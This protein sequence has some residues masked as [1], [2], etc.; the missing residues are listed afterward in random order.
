MLSQT[1][2]ICLCPH[3]EVTPKEVRERTL[4]TGFA[5]N[6]NTGACLWPPETIPRAE[7]YQVITLWEGEPQPYFMF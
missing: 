5:V 4:F 1:V 3:H 6:E 7:I 2:K